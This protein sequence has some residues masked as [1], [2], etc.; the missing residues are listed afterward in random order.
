MFDKSS[1]NVAMTLNRDKKEF[2]QYLKTR[3]DNGK[4]RKMGMCLLWKFNLKLTFNC[5]PFNFP[6]SQAK[7]TIIQGGLYKGRWSISSCGLW[8]IFSSGTRK[9]AMETFIVGFQTTSGRPCLCPKIILPR[10][11]CDSLN[12]LLFRIKQSKKEIVKKPIFKLTF[13]SLLFAE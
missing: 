7:A 9:I 8:N 11:L 12:F 13:I 3:Y 5:P 2:S 1:T 4:S 10:E 6:R